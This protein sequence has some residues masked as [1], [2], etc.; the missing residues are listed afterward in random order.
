VNGP[1]AAVDFLLDDLRLVEVPELPDWQSKALEETDANRKAQFTMRCA[2]LACT[3][4]LAITAL[5]I[6]I[7]L[8]ML[9]LPFPVTQTLESCM[10][11]QTTRH[12]SP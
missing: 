10:L 7:E 8:A 12:S 1:E 4:W 5:R 11:T 9:G 3:A 6:S 2:S